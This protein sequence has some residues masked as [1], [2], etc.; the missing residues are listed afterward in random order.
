MKKF[1]LEIGNLQSTISCSI[2]LINDRVTKI[3]PNTIYQPG[4]RWRIWLGQV[5]SLRVWFPMVLLK[6]FIIFSAALWP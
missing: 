5:G 6:F 1:C 4:M 2:A 3:I